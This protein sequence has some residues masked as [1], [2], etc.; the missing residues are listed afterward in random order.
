[1]D[2]LEQEEVAGEE[3]HL[4]NPL[5]SLLS[6]TIRCSSNSIINTESSIVSTSSLYGFKGEYEIERL[7]PTFFSTFLHRLSISLARQQMNRLRQSRHQ[8]LL[9]M[10][11][12]L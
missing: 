12:Q 7:T 6:T 2:R 3:T 8:D 9:K 5:L 4:I 1:M 11:S 10:L